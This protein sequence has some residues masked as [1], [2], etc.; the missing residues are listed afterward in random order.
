MIESDSLLSE[1]VEILQYFGI[2]CKLPTAE[3]ED[4]SDIQYFITWFLEENEP[5][6]VTREWNEETL[7]KVVRIFIPFIA[8]GIHKPTPV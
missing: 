1:I 8:A 7:L 3:N 2:I 4:G 6:I 5:E